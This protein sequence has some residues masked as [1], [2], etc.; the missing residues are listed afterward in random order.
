[1]AF[2]DGN[3]CDDGE[4]LGVPNRSEAPVTPS[5]VQRPND[6]AARAMKPR[7]LIVADVYWI[8]WVSTTHPPA[9]PPNSPLV[10]T[11]M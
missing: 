3:W 6:T 1:M 4:R 11:A 8:V 5:G 2:N 10:S 9:K 7:P